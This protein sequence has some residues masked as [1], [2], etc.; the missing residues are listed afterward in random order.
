MF[1]TVIEKGREIMGY[2]PCRGLE[3]SQNFGLFAPMVY[4]LHTIMY[5]YLISKVSNN[6]SI[7]PNK[8]KDFLKQF[9]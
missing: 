5:S 9:I 1:I 7:F 8:W 2:P 6:F 3:S 4:L